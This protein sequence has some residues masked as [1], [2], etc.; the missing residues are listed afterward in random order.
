METAEDHTLVEVP[1]EREPSAVVAG[2]GDV[3]DVEGLLVA[4]V[5]SWG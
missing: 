1:Y 5:Q 2:V 3:E 4:D